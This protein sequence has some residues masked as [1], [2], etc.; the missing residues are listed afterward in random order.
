MLETQGEHQVPVESAPLAVADEPDNEPGRGSNVAVPAMAH[1]DSNMEEEG[2]DN[3]P[4]IHVLNIG[5][6]TSIRLYLY[7]HGEYITVRLK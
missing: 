2:E 7:H 4:I 6:D 1:E 3:P 5:G